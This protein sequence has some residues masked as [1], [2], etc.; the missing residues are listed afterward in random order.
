MA[1]MTKA[2]VEHSIAAAA[3]DDIGDSEPYID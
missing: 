1:A 2:K 3:V